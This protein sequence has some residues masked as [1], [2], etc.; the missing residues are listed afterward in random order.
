MNMKEGNK[1]K[2]HAEGGIGLISSRL[3]LEGP[4][5]KNKSSFII[6]ARRTYLD[7]VASPLIKASQKN[8]VEKTTGGTIF[9]I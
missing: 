8:E 7:V 2:L 1:E 6:S 5:K 4:I 9:I 3:T